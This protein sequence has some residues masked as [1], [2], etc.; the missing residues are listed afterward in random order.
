MPLI[1]GGQVVQT[2]TSDDL[3]AY[4]PAPRERIESDLRRPQAVYVDPIGREWPLTEPALGW[5]TIDQVG[6]LGAV[7]VEMT[8]DAHPRGGARVRHI[9]PQAR[10]INWPLL[11]FGQTHTEFI[12][13]WRAL[14]RAFTMTRRLGPGRLRVSRPDGSSREI[15]VTYQGGLNGEAGQGFTHDTAVVSLYCEDPYWRA[16]E[17]LVTR[18]SFAT[19]RPF[20]RPFPSLSSGRVLGEVEI[21]NPGE[22]EAWPTWTIIGPATGLV[23]TNY[24]TGQSFTL[25]YSLAAGQ[26]ITVT[27]DPPTVRGPSGE[28]L[29]WALNWPGAVLWGLEPGLNDVNFSVPGA[30]PGSA[31][32]LAYV[33]RYETA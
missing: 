4:V 7:E 8:T 9:Q 5:A 27:T 25:S 33:P 15:L 10:V 13:R 28:V 26:T 23:A 32:D 16:T 29:T 14:V 6:G 1:I 20:L 31:V 19:L 2:P 17:Q 12:E 30:G 22:A 3:P 24:T 11:V 21:V 18:Y